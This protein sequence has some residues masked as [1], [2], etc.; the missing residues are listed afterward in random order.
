MHTACA[1]L[2]I[3]TEGARLVLEEDGADVDPSAVL[4]ELCAA[5]GIILMLLGANEH[6]SKRGAEDTTRRTESGQI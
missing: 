5:N 3:P 2:K 1:K 4:T 6:W